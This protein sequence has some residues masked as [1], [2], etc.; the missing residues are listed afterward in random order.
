MAIAMYEKY[1]YRFGIITAVTAA[2]IMILLL[3]TGEALLAYA[4]LSTA[5]AYA[6]ITFLPVKR[7]K[8]DIVSHLNLSGGYV[9]KLPFN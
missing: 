6:V 7:F 2:S 1:I 4:G 3:T 8:P 9:T 5:L